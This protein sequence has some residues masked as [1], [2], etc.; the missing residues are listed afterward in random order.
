[1]VERSLSISGYTVSGW[2]GN[3]EAIYPRIQTSSLRALT[4]FMSTRT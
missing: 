4:R 2:I 3:L 1:M